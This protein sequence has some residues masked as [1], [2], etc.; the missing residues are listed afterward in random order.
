MASKSMRWATMLAAI[1]AT[2]CGWSDATITRF[3]SATVGEGVEVYVKGTGLTM[4]RIIKVNANTS[5]IL[6]FKA[7]LAGRGGRHYVGVGGVSYYN[8]GWWSNR[9]DKVRLHVKL[10]D[11]KEPILTQTADGWTIHV[12]TAPVVKAD[13]PAKKVATKTFDAKP[14]TAH[15]EAHSTWLPLGTTHQ[16]FLNEPGSEQLVTSPVLLSKDMQSEVAPVKTGKEPKKPVAATK[17]ALTA[18]NVAPTVNATTALVATVTPTVAPT[19]APVK[20]AKE[21]KAPVLQVTV[22]PAATVAPTTTAK[23]QTAP[24]PI[25]NSA[26]Q[27]IVGYTT[28]ALTKVKSEMDQKVSLDFTNTDVVQVL[29]ALSLQAGVNIVT[30][31]EVKG[32]VTVSLDQVSVKDALDLVTAMADIRYAKVGHTFVVTTPA[33]YADM[34]RQVSG[35]AAADSET[36]VVPLYSG[37]GGQIKTAIY[38]SEPMETET[39]KYDLILPSD[40]TTV[41]KSESLNP[42]NPPKEGAKDDANKAS[43]ESKSSNNGQKD[44]YVLIVGTK[45]RIAEIETEVR[46]LDR[47][48]A[49]SLMITVPDD[50]S[51]PI[52]MSYASKNST[53]QS[54]LKSICEP[55]RVKDLELQPNQTTV[56]HVKAFASTA[57]GNADGVILLSGPKSEVEKLIGTLSE[58]DVPGMNQSAAVV[59][60]VKYLDPRALKDDLAI[61][62]P[63]LLVTVPPASAGNPYIYKKGEARTDAITQMTPWQAQAGKG[64]EGGGASAQSSTSTSSTT[65]TSTT[66]STATGD[67]LS[68]GALTLPYTDKE[69]F[70][71]PMRLVMRGNASQIQKA[72]QYLQLVDTAPKQ[73]AIEMRVMELS[74]EDAI[75]AGIDWNLFTGG[76]VKF[77]RLNNS[78]GAGTNNSATFNINGNGING[79]VVAQLDKISNNTNLI[80]R[81]N[82]IATDGRQTELFVGD[83]IRYVESITSSSNGVNVTTGTVRVGVRLAVMPRIG[84]GGN[85]LMEM[86]PAVSFLKGYVQVPQIGGQLPQTSERTAQ[87]TLTIANGETIAVGGLIQDQDRKDWQGLPILGDLPIIGSLFRRTTNDRVR[88]ELVVFVTVRQIDG[89]LGSG[90]PVLPMRDPE[91]TKDTKGKTAKK[92]SKNDKKV[93][94]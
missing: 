26:P 60:E 63:G 33:R 87:E 88:T 75:N 24:A 59:Y 52:A 38:K 58:L 48:I 29:K 27:K 62:F 47:E 35:T 83:A 93:G 21:P 10:K 14:F 11:D 67:A 70:A 84:A 91:P 74:K 1:G 3:T 34:V 9:P 23:K 86:R 57:N 46:R 64:A 20:T 81:P 80:A 89:A 5:Y 45:S 37:M 78:Q 17:A 36:I 28:T 65:T 30:S 25:K 69:M 18:T 50:D 42:E 90:S 79:D 68:G 31:P 19:S 12:H 92:D 49:H 94:S 85:I 72:V 51:E 73:V 2:A 41:T 39:G 15:D 55:A 61:Q 6:E 76:S 43:I 66:T 4:P 71:V 82:V 44:N 22:N 54:L 16:A 77:I 53:A 32:V 13:A 56:G 7:A 8:W 40:Q